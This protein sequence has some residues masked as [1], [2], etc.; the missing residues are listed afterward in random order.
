MSKTWC[1]AIV[2]N[3]QQIRQS[4]ESVRNW[5]SKRC[6]RN[7]KIREV[8]DEESDDDGHLGVVAL[9]A[10][11]ESTQYAIILLN[12]KTIT[13]FKINS[14][15]DVTVIGNQLE[16]DVRSTNKIISSAAKRAMDK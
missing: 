10:K 11:S 9:E 8:E 16:V 7:P 4:A 13:H 6:C 5:V 14:G 12:G 3:A 15:A 1:I 2:I